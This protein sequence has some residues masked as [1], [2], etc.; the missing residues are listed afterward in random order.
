M[1]QADKVNQIKKA[2]TA[3]EILDWLGNI[4]A[5][6]PYHIIQ[7]PENLFHKFYFLMS[8]QDNMF[9]INSQTLSFQASH[10]FGITIFIQDQV[11]YSDNLNIKP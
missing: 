2:N 5:Y 1:T 7:L 9:L 6:T 4:H 8:S 10:S 3:E 11:H